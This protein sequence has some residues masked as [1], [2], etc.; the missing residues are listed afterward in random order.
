VRG[1]DARTCVRGLLGTGGRC[2]GAKIK[3]AWLC[4]A[5]GAMMT[6][7]AFEDAYHGPWYEEQAGRAWHAWQETVTAL[8]VGTRVSGQVVERMPHG[9]HVA[10]DGHADAIGLVH[11]AAFGDLAEFP[12]P[13]S[14]MIAIVIGHFEE[15]RQ[16]WLQPSATPPTDRADES[17]PK[18][19]NHPP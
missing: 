7:V 6:T 5:M 12:E 10:I 18:P 15:T 13:G 8:P 3:F 19:R 14:Q 11:L 1:I 17:V 9:V 16:L 2:P 4:D